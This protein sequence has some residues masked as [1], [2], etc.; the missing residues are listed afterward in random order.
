MGDLRIERRFWH[1]PTGIERVAPVAIS[2][3][4]MRYDWL[5]CDSQGREFRRGANIR[6]RIGLL[7][8]EWTKN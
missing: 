7:A 5:F 1:V 2:T 8:D 3:N 4:L 6:T